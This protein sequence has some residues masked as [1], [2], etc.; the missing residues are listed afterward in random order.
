MLSYLLLLLSLITINWSYMK[1]VMYYIGRVNQYGSKF[2]GRVFSLQ[3]ICLVC[4]FHY[5]FL[6]F[7]QWSLPKSISDHSNILIFKRFITVVT[8]KLSGS[9]ILLI[10]IIQILRKKRIFEGFKKLLTYW[11]IAHLF[12]IFEEIIFQASDK[13]FNLW[14]I[15]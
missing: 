3:A 9:F 14:V 1:W 7:L 10:V 8:S 2:Y 4:F 12:L 5:S 6:F 13:Y 11:I 15:I